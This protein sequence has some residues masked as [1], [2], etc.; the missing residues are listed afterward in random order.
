[1]PIPRQDESK[2]EYISRCMSDPKMKTKH[3]DNDER[4]AVCNGIWETEGKKEE[5]DL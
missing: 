4:F 3:P 2:D 5:D 1:M